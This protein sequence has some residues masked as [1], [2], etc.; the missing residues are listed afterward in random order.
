[1]AN[2]GWIRQNFSSNLD[3]LRLLDEDVARDEALL[4]KQAG[5]Q[6][7]V[8]PTSGG[9]SRDPEA[10]ARIARATGL[11]IVMGA[12]YYVQ[13]AHPAG[14]AARSQED[15]TREIVADITTGVGSTG[16]RAGLIGEIGCTWPW[17]DDE[18]K[19]ARA[20]VAAQRQTGAPLMIHPGR[21]PRAPMQIMELVEKE[22][23]N[24][25][26]TIMCHI[27]RTIADRRHLMDLAQT[28]CYLEYDLFWL[29]TSYYPYNPDFDMPNDGGR[30][31]QILRLI[32]GL[33]R[34]LGMALILVTHDLGVVYQAVDRVAVMYAGQ[35]VELA[36]TS[37]LFARPRH[38]YT[39][40]LIAS[41]PSLDRSRPLAPIPGSPPDLVAVGRGCPFA[42]RCAWAS[43]ECRLAD[44]PLLP[45]GEEHWSR[46]IKAERL[47]GG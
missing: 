46:C 6:T 22:G 41:I 27:D 45:V 1:M 26:R 40:G 30:M 35:V 28:G 19:V 32:V 23:G 3:N 42:P 21:N 33:Q 47:A 5:G 29:E 9:L 17:T 25:K 8:D 20:A 24:P 39:I 37:E 12:G 10:L 31:A 43:E 14:L 38:P 36:P 13:A 16:V 2:L 18:K 15:I 34:A 11:N 44:I 4:F 7:M